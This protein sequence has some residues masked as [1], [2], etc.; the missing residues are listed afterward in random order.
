MTVLGSPE[1]FKVTTPID[2][3]LAEAVLAQR[4]AIGV[5]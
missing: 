1:A 4:R 2:L 5:R 3:L